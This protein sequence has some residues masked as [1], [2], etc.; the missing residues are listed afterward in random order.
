MATDVPEAPAGLLPASYERWKA[1]WTSDVAA[2]VNRQ[3]DLQR[4]TR[5]IEQVDRYDR[6]L[7]EVGTEWTVEGSMGQPVTNPLLVYLSQLDASMSRTE[8]EFGMTP[9]GRKRIAFKA[10]QPQ[11]D[12]DLLDEIA[13]RRARKASGA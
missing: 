8:S 6:I 1:F 12:G 13:Q 7:A 4:L 10:E 3:A 9:Q 2:C 5:W 11:E